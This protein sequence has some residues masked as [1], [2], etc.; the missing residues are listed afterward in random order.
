MFQN[1]QLRYGKIEILYESYITVTEFDTVKNLLSG[2]FEIRLQYSAEGSD[3][4]IVMTNGE[5][6][7]TFG[8]KD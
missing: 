3:S 4:I 7:L 5:F 2:E 8:L 6:S 1:M